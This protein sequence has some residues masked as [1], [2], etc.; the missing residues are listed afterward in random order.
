M[1]QTNVTLTA[2]STGGN[3]GAG[4]VRVYLAY[5]GGVSASNTAGGILGAPDQSHHKDVHLTGTNGKNSIDVAVIPEGTWPQ[6]T[7]VYFYRTRVADSQAQLDYEPAYL[8]SVQ[9]D[10]TA[11]ISLTMSDATLVLKQRMETGMYA[12][13]GAMLSGKF[14]S[15]LGMGSHMGRLCVWGVVYPYRLYIAG[16]TDVD[17]NPII[18]NDFWQYSLDLPG[19]DTLL[20]FKSFR[21]MGIAIGNDG[22]YKI[23]DDDSDPAYWAWQQVASL[24]GVNVACMEVINDIVMI[25]GRGQGGDIQ[26]FA[27]DGYGELM[28]IGDDMMGILDS[29]T[30]IL[31]LD[32]LPLLT[33]GTN[34]QRH[35]MNDKEQWGKQNVPAGVNKVCGRE[36]TY[37]TASPNAMIL[38]TSTGLYYEGTTYSEDESDYVETREYWT[39][40]EEYTKWDKLWIHA[41]AASATPVTATVY[42]SIDGADYVEAGDI[43]INDQNRDIEPVSLNGVRGR[44]L[45][46]KISFGTAAGCTI[47]GITVVAIPEPSKS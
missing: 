42:T 38:A 28:P 33:G 32:G 5:S 46:V 29:S 16:Y 23:Y 1:V 15:N 14:E 34:S 40:Y 35:V 31:S 26:I 3:M 44:R 25:V 13:P 30:G 8:D 19:R 27:Y 7:H 21:G 37:P 43:T 24:K 6:T 39:D 11:T 45:K 2:Q 4:Y 47:Q 22:L 41:V 36:A 17:G 9:V 10:T 20:D 12:F 18:D